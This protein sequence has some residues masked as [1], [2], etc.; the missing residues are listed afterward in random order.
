MRDQAENL[1]SM[2][3]DLEAKFR[4][5]ILEP[6]PGRCR[7]IAVTSG[8]GGVGKTNLALGLAITLA[9]A[10]YRVVLLDGDMGMA[11]IDVALGLYTKYDLSHVVRERKGCRRLFWRPAGLKIILAVLGLKNWPISIPRL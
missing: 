9:K 7:V 3:R 6:L 10:N 2:V 11:N 5:Q 4:A 8:K 1:R